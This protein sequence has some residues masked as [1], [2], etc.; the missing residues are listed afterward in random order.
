MQPPW[1]DGNTSYA[2]PRPAGPAGVGENDDATEAVG[3]AGAPR[4]PRV[5]IADHHAG[6][7]CTGSPAI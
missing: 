6:G 4:L 5:S 7:C 2:T 1:M 3:R